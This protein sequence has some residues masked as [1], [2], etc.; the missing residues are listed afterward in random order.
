MSDTPQELL[1][2]LISLPLSLSSALYEKISSHSRH[3]V[4]KLKLAASEI[5]IMHG[6]CA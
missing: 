3:L 5:E 2:A 6:T 1:Q 4:L